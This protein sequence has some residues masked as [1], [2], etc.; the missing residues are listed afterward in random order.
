[1][2][3]EEGGQSASEIGSTLTPFR[4]SYSTVIVIGFDTIGGLCGMC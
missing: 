1:M 4:F 3:R 2:K